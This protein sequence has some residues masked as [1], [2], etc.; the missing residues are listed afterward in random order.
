MQVALQDAGVASEVGVD[1][2]GHH[3]L[4]NNTPNNKKAILAFLQAHL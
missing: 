3:G 2:S 4:Q 1:G